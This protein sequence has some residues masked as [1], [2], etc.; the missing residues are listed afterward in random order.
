VCVDRSVIAGQ[1]PVLQGR[2]LL[3]AV[4]VFGLAVGFL[5]AQ[6]PARVRPPVCGLVLAGL[7]LQVLA[8]SSVIQA[9]YL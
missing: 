6:L 9:F 7:A 1:G 3:P 4:G 8:L 2:Y 5:I